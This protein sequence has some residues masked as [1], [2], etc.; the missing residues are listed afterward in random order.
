MN[1]SFSAHPTLCSACVLLDGVSAAF[2]K[3]LGEKRWVCSFSGH[4]E[5]VDQPSGRVGQA[6]CPRVC[7]RVRRALWQ[8][9][10]RS[11]VGRTESPEQARVGFGRL[12]DFRTFHDLPATAYIQP[13]GD[14][15]KCKS[16][17]CGLQACDLNRA[18]ICICNLDLASREPPLGVCLGYELQQAE[19]TLEPNK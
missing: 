3:A 13:C 12:Y 1:R 17:Q 5:T 9:W 6:L 10:T 18:L 11:V 4:L 8:G 2:A 16:S 7:D 15:R 19:C 14:H